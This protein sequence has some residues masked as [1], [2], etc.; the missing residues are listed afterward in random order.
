MQEY[1]SPF[2]GK[3]SVRDIGSTICVSIA[4]S[5]NTG[6][7]GD[8]TRGSVRLESSTDEFNTSL[9]ANIRA[10]LVREAGQE[11]SALNGLSLCEFNPEEIEFG[12]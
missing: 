11:R 2:S 12:N 4:N 9:L 8:K 1:G 7:V 6:N 5:V 10:L 3:Q